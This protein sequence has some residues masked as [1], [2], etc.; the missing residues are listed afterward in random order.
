MLVFGG[1]STSFIPSPAIQAW[2]SAAPVS[3]ALRVSFSQCS[4]WFA[5][6]MLHSTASHARWV[7]QRHLA[8]AVR[9]HSR[10]S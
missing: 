4:R 3:S 8:W 2:L 1:G 5:L 10:I 7:S 9:V 6:A